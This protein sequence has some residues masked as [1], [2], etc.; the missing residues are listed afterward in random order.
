VWNKNYPL[1]GKEGL[2]DEDGV[3]NGREVPTPLHH[4]RNRGGSGPPPVEEEFSI[5]CGGEQEETH[6]QLA[7]YK[8]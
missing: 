3:D 8:R 6:P 7:T 5:F 2:T 4:T 1:E